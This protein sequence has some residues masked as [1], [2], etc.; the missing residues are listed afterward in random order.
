M[1]TK[2][3][4]LKQSKKKYLHIPTSSPLSSLSFLSSSIIPQH[5]HETQQH[6]HF[7]LSSPSTSKSSTSFTG[8]H[9]RNN[10]SHTNQKNNIIHNSFFAVVNLNKRR[11]IVSAINHDEENIIHFSTPLLSFCSAVKRFHGSQP[12][13]NKPKPRT[14]SKN[15]SIQIAERLLK[16]LNNASNN[17]SSSDVI[18]RN[19]LPKYMTL[20]QV[21]NILINLSKIMQEVQQENKKESASSIHIAKL[22]QSILDQLIIIQ[23]SNNKNNSSSSLLLQH[24]QP[25]DI[26][27]NVV[28]NCWAKCNGGEY[29]AQKA[30]SLLLN[31]ILKLHNDNDINHYFS[32]DS[33][34]IRI[35]FHTVMD[36]WAKSKSGKKA[37]QIVQS[38]IDRMKQISKNNKDYDVHPNEETYAI[39]LDT[40]ANV[41]HLVEDAPEQ[42]SKI[43]N[44]LLLLHDYHNKWFASVIQAWSKNNKNNNNLSH[45]QETQTTIAAWFTSVIKAWSIQIKTKS[46]LSST[47]KRVAAA[48]EKAQS[49]LDQMEE[50]NLPSNTRTYNYVMKAWSNT[51]QENKNKNNNNKE[52]KLLNYDDDSTNDIDVIQKMESLLSRMQHRHIQPNQHSYGIF[53]HA[54]GKGE[55]RGYENAIRA[56][57]I[58]QHI[59]SLHH[60][61]ESDQSDGNLETQQTTTLTPNTVLFNTVINVWSKC[62][63]TSYQYDKQRR[64]DNHKIMPIHPAEKA[65]SLLNQLE[66]LGRRQQ[67][68][69][70]PHQAG[71]RLEPNTISFNSVITAW[72]QSSK[73]LPD[74]FDKKVESL[75]HRMKSYE[76]ENQ[77][78]NQTSSN[79]YEAV[80]RCTITFSALIDTYAKKMR[81]VRNNNNCGEGIDNEAEEDIIIEKAEKAFEEMKSIRNGNVKPNIKTF[82]RLLDVY[83]KRSSLSIRINDNTATYFYDN[84]SSNDIIN[85]TTQKR[86]EKRRRNRMRNT[87]AQRVSEIFQEI[88]TTTKN[89]RRGKTIKIKPDIITY[90]SCFNACAYISSC[91]SSSEGTDEEWKERLENLKVAYYTIFCHLKQA[92]HRKEVKPHHALV[93]SLFNLCSNLL[94]EEKDNGHIVIHHGAI[95]NNRETTDLNE[96]EMILKDITDYCHNTGCMSKKLSYHF[97]E[98]SR[99][100]N[101]HTTNN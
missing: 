73:S 29:A 45:H 23:N 32:K 7:S 28:L 21:N 17:R 43:L 2:T 22:A 87:T 1:L 91:N 75:I 41:A 35:S 70:Q 57:R 76:E 31:Q 30:Q 9:E 61:H 47:T 65:E 83:A 11:S 44:D 40:F 74:T 26:T 4:F 60:Q 88:L 66:H 36:A 82:N 58:L 81:I 59:L 56:E 38:L 14:R 52:K 86:R 3:A 13:N 20:L 46:M 94:L 89:T 50:M 15:N 25:N 71:F 96:V 85:Q 55:G 48:A 95:A 100:L 6:F 63:N 19:S 51:I 5:D 97:E 78:N 79:P 54:L 99:L 16:D 39:L 68:D 10:W 8:S 67:Q 84:S 24:L 53:I 80:F 92:T 33:S 42:A 64:Q 90:T 72:N 93:N 27:Y 18:R 49:L 12:N 37:P 77:K 69:V 62:C 34:S 98:I 101:S